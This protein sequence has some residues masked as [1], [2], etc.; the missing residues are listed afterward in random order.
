MKRY[1]SLFLALVMIFSGVQCIAYAGN[2]LEDIHYTLY[3]DPGDDVPSEFGTEANAG[4]V[5]T[6]K[7]VLIS[8]DNSFEVT[9]SALQQEYVTQEMIAEKTLAADVLF[10]MDMSTSMVYKDIPASSSDS[11]KGYRLAATVSAFNEAAQIIFGA[12]PNNRIAVYTFK[13][14]Y[15]TCNN[16]MPLD[17]YT[18]SDGIYM[19]ASCSSSS[20]K[21]SNGT[22]LKKNGSSYSFSDSTGYYTFLQA[23][24]AKASMDLCDVIDADTDKSGRQL[25]VIFLTDGAGT[26][27]TSSWYTY[28]ESVF[29]KYDLDGPDGTGDTDADIAAAQ[30]L[31]AT[32]WKDNLQAVYDTRNTNLGKDKTEIKWFN[33]GVMLSEGDTYNTYF[34]KPASLVNATTTKAKSLKNYI[35]TYSS[36]YNARYDYSDVSNLVYSD[37][38]YF[39]LTQDTISN[40]FDDLAELVNASTSSDVCYPISES[41]N[42]STVNIGDEIGEGFT[43]SNIYAT[44]P[45]GTK[46]RGDVDGNDVYFDGYNMVATLFDDYIAWEVPANEVGIYAYKDR[47]KLTGEMTASEPT[48]LSFTLTLKDGWEKDTYT[49]DFC[50]VAFAVDDD[51]PYYTDDWVVET[52]NKS[53]RVSVE[54]KYYDVFFELTGDVPEGYED[55]F[56]VTHVRLNSEV[57]SPVDYEAGYT[58]TATDEYGNVTDTW[59]FDGWDKELVCT[60]DPTYITG[61]WTHKEIAPEEFTVTYTW[62]GDYPDGVELP[63]S[64]RYVNG[65]VW[66]GEATYAP[67]YEYDE[68]GNQTGKWTFNGWDPD[69]AYV[70]YDITAYGSWTYEEVNVPVY[71]IDY[72]F[73][74]DVPEGLDVPE[75]ET[76]TANASWTN[77]Y[78]DYDAMVHED[79]YGNIDGYYIFDGWSV[80]SIDKVNEGLTVTGNWTFVSEDVATHN[81]TPIISVLKFDGDGNYTEDYSASSGFY[82]KTSEWITPTNTDTVTN[83]APWTNNW[84]DSPSTIIF[85][86]DQYGNVIG[87]YTWLGWAVNTLDYVTEDVTVPG[88]FLHETYSVPEYTINYECYGDVPDGITLPES[89]TIISG[90]SFKNSASNYDDIYVL[91][92]YGNQ[93]GYYK[94]Y[95]WET[96]EIDSVTGDATIKGLWQ[97][98]DIETT[99][100]SVSYK[101]KGDVPEGT[102]IPTDS[103]EYVN[104]EPIIE[105]SIKYAPVYNY[106]EYGNIISY[107]EFMGWEEHPAKIDGDDVV[108]TGVWELKDVVINKYYVNYNWNG[109]IPKEYGVELPKDN[110]VY[111]NNQPYYID[112]TFGSG[113]V[114]YTYDTYGN[115]DGKYVFT[116][117]MN[118]TSSGRIEGSDVNLYGTWKY[119]DIDVATGNIVYKFNMNVPGVDVPTDDYDYTVNSTATATDK[120]NGMTVYEYDDY[121]NPTE[122]WTFEGWDAETIV[123]NEGN[124]VINGTWTHEDVEVPTGKV[125]YIYQGNVPEDVILPVDDHV[126]VKGEAFEVAD[127]PSNVYTY[128]AYGNETGYY[129]MPN[130]LFNPPSVEDN[131]VM[132]SNGVTVI[133]NW[134]YY[135][136]EVPTGAIIYQFD[137][138]SPENATIP[139]DNNVYVNNQPYVIADKPEDVT[140]YD[141]YGNITGV[142]TFDGWSAE[143]GVFSGSDDLVVTGSWTYTSKVVP[144]GTIIYKWTFDGYDENPTDFTEPTDSKTYTKGE[145]YIVDGAWPEG[146]K[147][148][149]YDIYGNVNRVYTFGGWDSES[150]GTFPGYDMTIEGTWSVEDVEVPAYPVQYVYEGNSPEGVEVPV[151]D[152][153]YILNSSYNVT[154]DYITVVLVED[155]Y[156]NVYGKWSF[157]GWDVDSIIISESNIVTG[158]WTYEDVAVPANKITYMVDGDVPENVPVP[159]DDNTYV[160]GQPFTLVDGYDPIPHYDNFGNVDGYYIFNGWEDTYGGKMPDTPV[161]I[162]GTWSFEDADVPTHDI[163]FPGV[164]EDDANPPEIIE[165]VNGDSITIVPNSGTWRYDGESYTES[166]TIIITDDTYIPDPVREGWTFEGWDITEE[167]GHVTLTAKWEEIPVIVEPDPV[168]IHETEYVPVVITNVITTGAA[169]ATIVAGGAVA[170]GVIIGA[171]VLGGAAIVAT[172]GIIAKAI[173]DKLNPSTD[174]NPEE[175][176]IADDSGNTVEYEPVPNTGSSN[177]ATVFG[178]IFA[179][180]AV[181]LAWVTISKKRKRK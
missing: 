156:G 121:G 177:I 134:S 26:N 28:E 85:D 19:K 101:L 24:I 27:A 163:I 3:D 67:I 116:G 136:E 157:N 60:D 123:I 34:M 11:S 43:I 70:T 20:G 9:L 13:D 145:T 46:V 118:G 109:D 51:N 41:G 137:G 78:P 77:K 90:D 69:A 7:S 151:D 52:I 32:F 45:D 81:V 37:Y 124:N 74:G 56:E 128:D 66:Y 1:L 169:A 95:G 114:I 35:S 2:D 112:D 135:S 131:Q 97:Y 115:V 96:D 65:A 38:I 129:I 166:T 140:T 107:N 113:C 125:N 49:N 36:K 79:K 176:V 68:Y 105:P 170:G 75:I 167:N 93:I 33:V 94:F 108:I 174:T 147:L 91:D 4:R 31:T 12:N 132:T 62:D 138:P 133:G 82:A 6:D 153:N 173:H 110:N 172:V 30:L 162:T 149:S 143:D 63:E 161:V 16:V 117:W 142:W 44:L 22:N 126:Y 103:H 89:V 155:D 15:G 76:V 50:E 104:N 148:Y 165:I 18:A 83:G 100:Y 54:V 29:K 73:T 144:T 72:I 88:Y 168:I 5:W 178:V 17:S 164:K 122:K 159:V 98:Y 8:G 25:F 179:M 160:P 102:V 154:S 152:G 80:Y 47:N 141:E 84:G 120:L 55:F 71:K 92:D 127:L 99:K 48:K 119:T 42:P 106:D 40:A 57:N 86:Y 139:V 39:S 175:K 59:T 23:G 53:G 181:S 10:I 171:A 87:T 150:H 158:T 111:V 21:I 64:E 180:A 130:W 58:I 14:Q 146:T 61:H